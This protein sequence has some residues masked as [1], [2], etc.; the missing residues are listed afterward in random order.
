MEKQ[1]AVNTPKEAVETAKKI[2]AENKRIEWVIAT[3]AATAGGVYMEGTRGDLVLHRSGK[4]TY[5]GV[6][7]VEETKKAILESL[8]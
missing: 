3:G 2:F 8:V 5:T 6:R 4:G 1:I 7:T